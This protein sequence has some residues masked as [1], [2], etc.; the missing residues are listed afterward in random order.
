[1]TKQDHKTLSQLTGLADGVV[2]AASARRDPYL[3]VPSRT[4]SNVRYNK[5]K[6]FIEMGK[7]SQNGFV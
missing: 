5:R 2:R 7:P 6:Q 1:M 3:D 4:L